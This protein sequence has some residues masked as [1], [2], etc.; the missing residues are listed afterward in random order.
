[1]RVLS[2]PDLQLGSNANSPQFQVLLSLFPRLVT[3]VQYQNQ[4]SLSTPVSSSH[5]AGVVTQPS[6]TQ[7]AACADV[8]LPS[9]LGT[10]SSLLLSH[11]AI[12]QALRVV[13]FTSAVHR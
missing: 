11:N 3:S 5:S 4:L 13:P 7:S 12:Y 8:D 10:A 6:N 9:E 1:M 2:T